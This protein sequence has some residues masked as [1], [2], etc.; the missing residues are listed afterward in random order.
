MVNNY[1]YGHFQQL[2]YFAKRWNYD[3]FLFNLE[4]QMEKH[5]VVIAVAVVVDNVV[6]DMIVMVM[7][8]MNS[9]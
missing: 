3:M 2:C 1:F 4:H 8:A 7:M 9:T 6:E 5:V